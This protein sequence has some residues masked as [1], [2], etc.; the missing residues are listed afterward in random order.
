M[1][2]LIPALSDDQPPALEPTEDRTRLFAAVRD[3]LGALASERRTA[4]VL[5]D[6]HWADPGTLDLLTF[7]VR[8]LPVGTALVVTS[9]SN[10]LPADY[11]V[12]DW[13]SATGRLRDVEPVVLLPLPP[14]DVRELV[15]SLVE[16][17]PDAT[18]VAD[19]VRR[20]EGSP[21]FTEQLVAAARD[22]APPLQGQ[23]WVPPD[24][25]QMLLARV[26]SVGRAA[27]DV[28]SVL[29]VAARPLA[30]PEL[31]LCTSA[32]VDVAAG[33][34]EL[35]G[36]HL[37]EPADLDRYRLRH[38][39]L[40]DTVRGTLLA[41]HR[42]ALHTGVARALAA[43]GD[44]SPAEIAAHWS[45]AGNHGEE[46][47]WSVRAARHAE[48]VFAWREASA[49]W[50]RV[51]ELWAALAPEER[52]PIGLA[53]AVVAAVADA[54]RSDDD[55]NFDRLVEEAL[56]D[57][58]V[59]SDD[60]ATGQ[61]LRRQGDRLASVDRTAS[62]AALER[63]V[64]VFDSTGR[65][66]AEQAR[67][68]Q[69]LAQTKIYYDIRTGTEDEELERATNIAEQVGAVDVLIEIEGD[70]STQL[71][72]AGEVE[73]GLRGLTAALTRAQQAGTEY[74]A[75]ITAVNLSDAYVWLLRLPEGIDVGRRAIERALANGYRDSMEFSTLVVNTFDGLLL[76]GD[77]DAAEQLL[78][79]Y[80]LADV[81]SNGWPLHI[82]R[83]ELDLLGGD[84]DGALARFERLQ[85][86]DDYLDDEMQMWLGEVGAAAELWKNRPA[87]AWGRTDRTWAVFEASFLAFRGSRLLA[88]AARA[89]ADTSEVNP[90]PDR[91]GLAQQL[92]DRAE[93]AECFAPHP[94][95]VLGAAFGVTFEAELARLLRHGGEAEWRAA[96]DTWAGHDVPHHAAYAGWRL[97]EQLVATGRRKEAEAE[98]VAAYAMAGTHVPLRREIEGFARRARL[99]LSTSS[100]TQPPQIDMARLDD[101]RH[102]LTAR[103][104][105]VL[106]LLGTG[107]TNA[108][109]GR[110]LYMSPKTASVHVSAIIRKLGVSGRVQAATVA[111][112]MGLLEHE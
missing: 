10:E 66:S 2:A 26:R 103:E 79:P 78:V 74:V 15:S 47:R 108:E 59:A 94:G 99:P 71:L 41:S 61:L 45:R 21:F 48:S 52:P 13:L 40:A 88:L 36:C 58:R 83:A 56:A 90:H 31:E 100:D 69:T 54:G 6:L 17:A 101:A 4:L 68:L 12:V 8:R 82:A 25:A 37:A 20:G 33:L 49:C 72:L 89:A 44:E 32:D 75:N 80:L 43:R 35:L 19:V 27:T 65:P 106:R 28:A 105:D 102:G 53:E 107:A 7:L 38:A 60:Q 57:D 67:A 5:E 81:T 9:R 50:H 76:S 22:V 112:R 84:L 64:A 29:A 96:R 77:T 91:D 87:S 63:A 111:E 70:R 30:E 62:L 98:L 11:P 97:S 34:R 18:F 86:M 14:D 39:L 85:D 73:E 3:L 93:K 104:L 92:R 42:V 109:I 46:A 55:T 1:A 95:R 110:R 23:A 16:G 51:W 24:V